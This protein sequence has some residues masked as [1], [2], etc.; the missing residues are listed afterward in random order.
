MPDFFTPSALLDAFSLF[1]LVGWSAMFLRAAYMK[2]AIPALDA[3]K[4]LDAA[5]PKPLVSIVVPACNEAAK[6]R[7]SLQSLLRQD[8]PRFELIVINDRSTDETGDIINDLAKQDAR[9]KAIHVTVLPSGWL[10]KNHANQKGVEASSGE[11]ILFTD[12]DILFAPDTLSKTVAYAETQRAK[13]IVIYPKMLAEHI[14]EEAFI[15]LFALLF[16]WKFSPTGA[17]NPNNQSAYIGVGAFNFIKRDLYEAFGGHRMLK[18]EVAD[19]VMLGYYV[20]RQRE[21]THVLGGDSMVS[22]RWRNGLW[23]SVRGIERSA[24]PGVNFS[25]GWVLIGIAGTLGGLVAPYWLPMLPN[26]FAQA[27]GGVSIG[28]IFLVYALRRPALKAL[29]YTALHP[30]MSLLFLYGFLKSAIG[31]TLRGGVEWRGTFYS[32]D[33]LRNHAPTGN[34]SATTESRTA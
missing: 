26:G 21:G 22:V 23:D 1:C 7:A 25:W 10:G 19:D 31:I 14:L 5:T 12:A 16:T 8:Y 20:K 32:I 27:C 2:R 29:A 15:A 18:S 3:I 24:F 13:H 11:Y 17:K 30:L 4:P 28:L 9:I 34:V 6:I 33:V